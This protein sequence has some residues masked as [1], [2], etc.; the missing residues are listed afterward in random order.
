MQPTV[1]ARSIVVDMVRVLP[2][3]VGG[4]SVAVTVRLRVACEY[5]IVKRKGLPSTQFIVGPFVAS[6]SP[7]SA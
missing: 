6:N 5:V 7:R 3:P 4:C 2:T 1:A